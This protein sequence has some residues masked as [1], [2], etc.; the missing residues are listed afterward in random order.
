MPFPYCKVVD[1]Y[2]NPVDPTPLSSNF[3]AVFLEVENLINYHVEH[4]V[5]L[6]DISQD[7]N[8]FLQDESNKTVDFYRLYRSMYEAVS[9]LQSLVEAYH[10]NCGLQQKL[11]LA[12]N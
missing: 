8:N 11:P 10:Q 7:N 5:I 9:V 1:E 4:T 12:E 6:N 2:W 3:A